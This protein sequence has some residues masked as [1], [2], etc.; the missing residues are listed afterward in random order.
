MDKLIVMAKGVSPFGS[1]VK[2]DKLDVDAIKK[3]NGVEEVV[4]FY[5]V[6]AEVEFNKEKRYAYAVG[7]DFKEHKTLFE[8]LMTVEIIAGDS[9]SS[10]DKSKAVLGYNYQFADKIFSKPINLGDKIKVNGNYFT[11]AGFYGAVGS[12]DDDSHVYVTEAAAEDV[13]GA[14]SY[15]EIFARV[16]PG[17]NSTKIAGDVTK[18]LR[19]HRNQQKGNEDFFAQTFEQV[20]QTF[21]A[22][23]NVIIAVVVLIAL[24]SVIV[25]SVNIMN[26]MYASILERTKEIGIFKAIGAK[27][28]EILAIFMIESGMLSLIGGIIGIIIGFLIAK[29]AGMIISATG[30]GF[31]Q[32]FFNWQMVFSILLFSFLIGLIAGFLP[33]RNASRLKPVEALRY[34]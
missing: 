9:L 5:A 13:L 14:T 18:G 7:G 21:T 22:V 1:S 10:N 3:V 34:E 19:T 16:S 33:A 12:P 23:L 24:I 26:T 17:E 2:F 6:S 28:S 32:P 30:Y 31:L 11:V 25:A 8:E 20:I 29:T 4:G 27:N 15:S